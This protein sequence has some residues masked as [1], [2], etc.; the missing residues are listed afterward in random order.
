[1]PDTLNKLIIEHFRKK[2]NVGKNSENFIAITIGQHK[3]RSQFI[4]VLLVKK[5]EA[6]VLLFSLY[7][8]QI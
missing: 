8:Y 6:L 3:K 1:M 7:I 4:L 5:H 2:D